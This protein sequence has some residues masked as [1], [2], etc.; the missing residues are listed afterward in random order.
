MADLER[1]AIDLG[2]R[3]AL[4]LVDV[5]YGFADPESPLGHEC[6]ATLENIGLL[7]AAFRSRGLPAFYANVIYRNPEEA[8][9]F[10]ERLPEMEIL[11]HGS[12][13][14]QIVEEL[15]PADGETVIEKKWASSFF[16]TDLKS[17]LDGAGVDS[18]I[19]TGLTTS[20]CVRATA[21]DGLQYNYPVLVPRDACSDR[22]PAAHESNLFDLNAKYVDVVDTRDVLARLEN[23]KV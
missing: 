12:R 19:V 15:K 3:P 2:T 20:G 11:K 9:V 10:R 13:W 7:L 17:R 16:A 8:S 23:I 4:I 6:A 1:R 5:N 14:V 21:V 22:N 18:L